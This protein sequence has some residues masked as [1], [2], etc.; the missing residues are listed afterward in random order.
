MEETYECARP[1]SCIA[2][3]QQYWSN[4][5]Q[6]SSQDRHTAVQIWK[7][8]SIASHFP[9]RASANDG[10]PGAY[11]PLCLVRHRNSVLPIYQEVYSELITRW[12][13]RNYHP[14]QWQQARQMH[15]P[16]HTINISAGTCTA[17]DMRPRTVLSGF[18]RVI[19]SAIARS[20]HMQAWTEAIL[21]SSQFGDI[22]HRGLHQALANTSA[23]H[24]T[25]TNM[26]LDYAKCFDN[27][28]GAMALEIMEQAGF[29]PPLRQL[30]GHV[31]EHQQRYIQFQQAINTQ[32]AIVTKSLPQGDGVCATSLNILMSEPYDKKQVTVFSRRFS[33]TIGH[34]F[35]ANIQQM[36]RWEQGWAQWSAQFGLEED[37]AVREQARILGVDFFDQNNKGNG[38]TM[39]P[40]VDASTAMGT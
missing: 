40:R 38:A 14:Q 11:P 28:G 19:T 29:S 30:L 26:S 1:K 5:W 33:W 12:M 4:T 21:D 34:L 31:W 23:H 27:P 36:M 24:S 20:K 39:Q 22:K 10:L 7:T 17:S 9:D 6:R 32:A 25:R 35:A 18:W 13:R 3:I 37:T 16:K 2:E 8:H 15:I